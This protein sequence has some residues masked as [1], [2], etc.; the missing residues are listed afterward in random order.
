MLDYVRFLAR[1]MKL[2]L[3]HRERRTIERLI[4]AGKSPSP[5][6]STASTSGRPLA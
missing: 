6:A 2:E 3:I 4:K 5:R 1:L